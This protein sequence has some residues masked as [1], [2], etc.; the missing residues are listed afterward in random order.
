MPQ[1]KLFV[2]YANQLE[3][4]RTGK[5]LVDVGLATNAGFSGG[6]SLKKLQAIAEARING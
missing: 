1:I 2:K 4:E 3:N 5:E 6:E